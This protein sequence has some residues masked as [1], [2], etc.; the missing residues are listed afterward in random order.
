M[1]AVTL[2]ATAYYVTWVL[3][4][5]VLPIGEDHRFRLLF[6]QDNTLAIAVPVVTGILFFTGLALFA[7]YQ[8]KR[9]E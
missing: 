1:L 5:P 9:H 6:P 7:V 4:L 8:L 3:L 2:T